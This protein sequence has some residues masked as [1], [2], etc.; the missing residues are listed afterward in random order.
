MHTSENLR[1]QPST[2]R[3]RPCACLT[4][5]P[6]R[7]THKARRKHDANMAF[8]HVSSTL[9][10]WLRVGAWRQLPA[11]AWPDQESRAVCGGS[12]SLSHIF[13]QHVGQPYSDDSIFTRRVCDTRVRGGESMSIITTFGRGFRVSRIEMDPIR[14]RSSPSSPPPNR[15][16]AP[17]RLQ[18]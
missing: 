4:R 2:V 10:Q 12:S 18:K 6:R 15:R 13:L 16:R 1:N 3:F 11:S 7:T 14:E 5:T 17:S 8:R 9:R